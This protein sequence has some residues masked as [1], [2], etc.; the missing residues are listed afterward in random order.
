MSSSGR[1]GRGKGRRLLGLQGAA[2]GLHLGQRLLVEVGP[3]GRLGEVALHLAELGQVE[4]RNL[5]RLLDLLLVGL[6]LG[7]QLVNQGLEGTEG[8]NRSIVAVEK[9]ADQNRPQ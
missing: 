1:G 4:G 2:A 3:L 7:L 6:D 5:L 8:T 9:S